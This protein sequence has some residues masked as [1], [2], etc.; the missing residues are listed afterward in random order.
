MVVLVSVLVVSFAGSLWLFLVAFLTSCLLLTGNPF[1]LTAV[2]SYLSIRQ[3]KRSMIL[4][5]LDDPLSMLSAIVAAALFS[6]MFLPNSK[7]TEPRTPKPDAF[8]TFEPYEPK[9]TW[10]SDWQVLKAMWFAKITGTDL[11]E[12]LVGGS[13]L[14]GP[15][16]RNTD[17]IVSRAGLESRENSVQTAQHPNHF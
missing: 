11:Q 3:S 4:D 14:G 8:L 5:V 1:S 17:K 16:R 13:T 9:A 10:A 15:A 2:S 7:K 6:A 12:R